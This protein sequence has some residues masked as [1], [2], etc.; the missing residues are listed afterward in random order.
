MRQS[1][2]IV[3]AKD[4]I[5]FNKQ[6]ILKNKNNEC[7]KIVINYAVYKAKIDCEYTACSME[8]L[9]ELLE[10]IKKK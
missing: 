3:I 2:F 1:V 9:K 10:K 6:W 4:K 7:L 5:R 8:E